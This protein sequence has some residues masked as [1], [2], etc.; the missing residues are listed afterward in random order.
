MLPVRAL[1]KKKLTDWLTIALLASLLLIS[2]RTIMRTELSPDELPPLSAEDKDPMKA[3]RTWE[4]ID[5]DTGERDTVTVVTERGVGDGV[6]ADES[7]AAWKARHLA[8]VA[9]AKAV[10]PP[11]QGD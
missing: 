2:V 6:P 11:V 8:R 10:Y 9:E 1:A 5:P 4:W 7:A 3:T